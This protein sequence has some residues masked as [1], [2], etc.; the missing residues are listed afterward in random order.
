[1]NP[2]RPL[3]L[4]AEVCLAL[5]TMSAVV[6]MGRLFAEGQWLVPL[7]VHAAAAHL[8]VAI[9]RRRGWSLPASAAVTIVGVE[10]ALA[11]TTYPSTTV[12]GLPSGATLSTMRDDLVGAWSLYQDVVAPVPVETGFVVASAFALWAVAFV[13]DWAAF[14][15][16]VPFEAILPAGTLF[17]FTALLGHDAGRGLAV[18][19][20][21]GATLAFFL[22]HRMSRLQATSHWVAGRALPGR[23]WLVGSG[24]GLGV[25]AVLLGTVVGPSLPG[26]DA[27]G[28]INPR[29]LGPG[30]GSRVTISPLVDIRTRLVTQSDVVAFEVQS[31]QPSYWRLTSLDRF[32][33]RIWS[34]SGS[35]TRASGNLPRSTPD[36]PPTASIEQIF[37]IAGLSAIWLPTAFEPR[38]VDPVDFGVL[39]D[40]ASSTLI[41]DREADTSD[42]LSYGVVSETPRLTPDDLAG[43]AGE[44]PF[45][46][47]E[48][49]LQLP[50]DFPDSVGA[51]AADLTADA[52]TPYEQALALQA[53][54]RTFTYDLDVGAGHSDAVLEQFLFE[55]RRGYCEQFAGAFAAMARSVG[56]PA[57][58]AVGFTQGAQDAG[59][60]SRYTVRGEHAHA[61]P[62]VHFAGAGW[63]SFEPTP[64]RGQPFAEAYTGVPAAQAASAEPG[65]ATTAPPT[66]AADPTATIPDAGSNPDRG[67]D[68]DLDA[69]G[70]GDTAGG[71]SDSGLLSRFVLDPV[72]R[73]APIVAVLVALYLVLFPMARLVSRSRRRRN[74]ISPTQ[75]ID[76]AW[77][78]ASDAAAL[79]GYQERP[80]HTFAERAVRLTEALPG[81]E[82]GERARRLAR[83]L[84][85]AHYSPT[86]AD[87]LEAE[88]ALECSAVLVASAHAEASL[89]ARVRPWLDPRPAVAA[90]RRRVRPTSQFTTT[91]R[92]TREADEPRVPARPG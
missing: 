16:W 18:G 19:T 22:T 72:R 37:T 17:L 73:A 76:L 6:G 78:E 69:I 44:V 61:W 87:H 9:V 15:L 20:F 11:W 14:R 28:V 30:E 71:R 63:V 79:H 31:S 1:M 90:V 2:P 88:L 10:L 86:G 49:Y 43:V 66:T 77:A 26:A 32:D 92:G 8:V 29:G 3:Q 67:A 62:E 24:L 25:V 53:H 13:A 64:G 47:G 52:P 38:A 21:A 12:I 45:D 33:G 40:D 60:P 27:D 35:Y 55:T 51:L 7:L 4:S 57:R 56:L 36:Q 5:V 50:G 68:G 46:E 65:V 54:L 89:A 42:G 74:A 81:D 80:T 84:D 91:A 23:R 41:V 59:D 48:R 83:S 85:L 82:Q 39:Y 70:G 75:R 34:S 58:V